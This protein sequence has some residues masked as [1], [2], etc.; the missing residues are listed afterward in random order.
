MRGV[1]IGEN[2]GSAMAY[3]K[4]DGPG[5]RQ[6]RW[7]G[8]LAMACQVRD[9]RPSPFAEGRAAPT[10]K[11]QLSPALHLDFFLL[12]RFRTP[13]GPASDPS[14]PCVSDPNS[15]GCFPILKYTQIAY[16]M[17]RKELEAQNDQKESKIRLGH[18]K[19]KKK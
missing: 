11:Q 12:S 9:S 3:C 1:F 4:G 14:Y 17:G 16:K 18:P 15:Y 7:A 8:H 5:H 10:S 2:W 19:Q 6:S 13:L